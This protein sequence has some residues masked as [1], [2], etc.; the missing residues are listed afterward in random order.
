MAEGELMI[1]FRIT[2]YNVDAHTR[3]HTHLYEYTYANLTPMSTSKG[4]SWQILRFTKLPQASRC[5]R[6]RRLPLKA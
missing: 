5:R 1:F 6:G 2:Q 4:L 3:T